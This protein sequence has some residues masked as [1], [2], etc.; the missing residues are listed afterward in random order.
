MKIDEG[1]GTFL[2]TMEQP[3]DRALLVSLEVGSIG[4]GNIKTNNTITYNCRFLIFP[5]E[6]I[7]ILR[8]KKDAH[9][10]LKVFF[11]ELR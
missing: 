10:R 1:A 5:H 11:R 6:V 7:Y 9:L 3:V 4:V 8:A 2:G